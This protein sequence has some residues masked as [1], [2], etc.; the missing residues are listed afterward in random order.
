MNTFATSLMN[1]LWRATVCE[2]FQW[3]KIS[4]TVCFLQHSHKDLFYNTFMVLLCPFWIVYASVSA[5]CNFMDKGRENFFGIFPFVFCGNILWNKPYHTSTSKW[6]FNIL[7][8]YLIHFSLQYNHFLIV[9]CQCFW[10]SCLN[11]LLLSYCHNRVHCFCTA[12]QSCK[13]E[14]S[15]R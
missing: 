7:S 3:I 2:D 9:G 14:W 6:W 8:S 13:P 1:A 15:Y 10:F 12:K 11:I 5:H 4:I